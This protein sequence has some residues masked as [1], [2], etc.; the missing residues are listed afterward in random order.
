MDN[1]NQSPKQPTS[2]A[3]TQGPQTETSLSKYSYAKRNW[4]KLVLIYLV[5]AIA[6]YI[7]VYVFFLS[8][9]NTQALFQ[10]QKECENKTGKKCSFN[11]CQESVGSSQPAGWCK[12]GFYP[13]EN[14]SPATTAQ[15]T[16]TESINSA[17]T[18][19]WN[20]YVNEKMGIE[21]RYP[22]QY[23]L[24]KES[25]TD[26]SF[27]FLFSPGNQVSPSS[28]TISTSNITDV[29]KTKK[30]S[31][32]SSED[33]TECIS[34]EIT[35]IKL[36]GKDALSFSYAPM[37]GFAPIIIQTT[38]SPKIEMQYVVYGGGSETKLDQILA[39][40]KFTDQ[41]DSENPKSICEEKGG[42]WLG[43]Y[44]ECEAISQGKGLDKATC[45]SLGGKFNEC[46]SA[47]RHNPKA[48]ACTM[49]CVSVCKF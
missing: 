13:Y 9:S 7:G 46:D 12:T 20:T 29:K 26:V 14:P 24:E 31:E 21:F 49:V 35:Q 40:F 38:N 48:E 32:A 22:D 25:G 47:C 45:T 2:S 44:K 34:G 30:C 17:E 19:N 6:L 42:T 11:M 16:L 41:V 37:G 3:P 10:S 28:L 15:P 36:G 23:K 27:S 1:P 18:A 8:K 33:K 43:T 5:I 4:K 39:T